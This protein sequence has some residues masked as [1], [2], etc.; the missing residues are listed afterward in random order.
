VKPGGITLLTA[1]A[2]A[3][4]AAYPHLLT[5]PDRP[6]HDL[7]AADID[8]ARQRATSHATRDSAQLRF[9]MEV[10]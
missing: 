2:Q 4:K 1:Q 5:P 7:T 8:A 3:L 10:R 6:R 9:D